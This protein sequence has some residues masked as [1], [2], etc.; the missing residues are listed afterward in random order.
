MAPNDISVSE[1]ITGTEPDP[2]AERLAAL[3]AKK[4]EREK[5]EREQGDEYELALLEL[6]EHLIEKTK[7]KRGVDFAIVETLDGP[8]AVT[9]GPAVKYTE[10]GG[11][12]DLSKAQTFVESCL[13][14]PSKPEF[15]KIAM[16]RPGVVYASAIALRKLYEG[17]KERDT[18]KR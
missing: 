16:R 18:G 11:S 4:A 1:S 5:A 7:G 15:R 12:D 13:E 3:R 2:K 14:S 8:I 10:W 17:E 9:L 6:E